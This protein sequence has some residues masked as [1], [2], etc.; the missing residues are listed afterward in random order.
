MKMN[1]FDYGDSL[2]FEVKTYPVEPFKETPDDPKSV[3][4]VEL[5]I[6]KNGEKIFSDFFEEYEED[7]EVVEGKYHLTLNTYDEIDDHGDY[8]IQV[9]AIM[10]SSKQVLTDHLKLKEIYKDG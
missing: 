2:L 8:K 9:K 4:S 3:D 10:G 5:E 7:G 6:Y 1:I